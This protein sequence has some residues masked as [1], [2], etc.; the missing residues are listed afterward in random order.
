[1][2][3]FVAAPLRPFDARFHFFESLSVLELPNF[4]EITPVKP[5]M[6]DRVVKQM[7]AQ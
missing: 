3:R 5:T 1:M 4:R 2:M 7:R 6:S